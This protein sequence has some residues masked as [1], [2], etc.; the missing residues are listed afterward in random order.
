MKFKVGD[1][2]IRTGENVPEFTTGKTYEVT[3]AKEYGV[4]IRGNSGI[5]Y[6][7]DEESIKTHFKRAEKSN[8]KRIKALEA[9]IEE[10]EGNSFYDFEAISE[11]QKRVEELE[12][13]VVELRKP[14]IMDVIVDAFKQEGFE[15]TGEIIEFE[16]QRYRKVDR[17]AKSGDV[18]VFRENKTSQ[19]RSTVGKP[20]LVVS[21]PSEKVKFMGDDGE[22]YYVYVDCHNRTP[23]TVD[24]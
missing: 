9:R 22:T 16:G 15:K 3:I 1:K 20:Y 19:E 10:F 5:G 14:S 23:K 24:V 11:L 6:W 21:E 7:F 8:K 17:E 4:E 18:V 13:F 2:V 12:R